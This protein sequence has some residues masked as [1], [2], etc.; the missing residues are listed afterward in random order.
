M[1]T[2]HQIL[3]VYDNAAALEA[4]TEILNTYTQLRVKMATNVAEARSELLRDRYDC[5]ISGYT[6][7]NS[8]GLEFL[9]EV[10]EDHPTLPFLLLADELHPD[11]IRDAFDAELTDYVTPQICQASYDLLVHRIEQAIELVKDPIQKQ[12]TNRLAINGNSA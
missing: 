12:D 3:F 10:R 11:I 8:T 6:Y 7:R 5:V 4:R 9:R 1:E 2:Q